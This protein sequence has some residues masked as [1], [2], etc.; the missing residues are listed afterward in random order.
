REL[1]AGTPFA[2]RSMPGRTQVLF[3]TPHGL[4]DPPVRPDAHDPE[5]PGAGD[6]PHDLQLRVDHGLRAPGREQQRP[7]RPSGPTTD[8]RWRHSG[9]TGPTESSHEATIGARVVVRPGALGE[10]SEGGKLEGGAVA[11]P[12]H[13]AAATETATAR[14]GTRGNRCMTLLL[15][16]RTGVRF[17]RPRISSRSICYNIAVA[18]TATLVQLNQELLAALD[19]QAA[20]RGV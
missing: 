9:S 14:A 17:L 20:E 19:Q 3:R 16:L 11:G 8:D 10:A 4:D 13:A 6:A 18:R 2:A 1:P 12:V 7:Q 5:A 15:L